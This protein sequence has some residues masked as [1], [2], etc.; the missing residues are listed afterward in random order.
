MPKLLKRQENS[1]KNDSVQ[2]IIIPKSYPIEDVCPIVLSLGYNCFYV[3]E[4]S[5][6]YRVRQFNPHMFDRNRYYTV[7]EKK[8]IGVKYIIEY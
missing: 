6:Y 1:R 8:Y 7:N 5:N 2:S 3:E 4:T